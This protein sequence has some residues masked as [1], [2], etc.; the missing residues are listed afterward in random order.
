[1]ALAETLRRRWHWAGEG[2]RLWLGLSWAGLLLVLGLIAA[3]GRDAGMSYDEQLQ[4]QYGD[5]VV[6]WFAS[7]FKDDRATT[8]FDLYLYGGLFDAPA[9]W[10]ATHSPLG[11]LETR[12]LLTQLIA[13]LGI[14]ASWKMAAHVGGPR[15]GFFAGLTL[16]LTPCWIGHGMFNPKDI[17]FGSAAAFASLAAVRLAVGPAPLRWRDICL[18]GLAAGIALGVRPGGV[19]V[20]GYPCLAGGLRLLLELTRRRRE[21]E[22]LH[23]GALSLNLLACCVLVVLIAWPVMISAWP[24]AQLQPLTRPLEGIEAASHFNWQNKV[25]FEGRMIDSDKLPLRYLPV[26]FRLTLPETYLLAAM[27][28]VVMLVRLARHRSWRAEPALGLAIIAC[29]VV[30]P[31]AA[32]FI[33]RPVLYDAQRHVL[34]LLPPTAALAGCALSELLHAEWLPRAL[35]GAAAGVLV[36]SAIMVCVDMV[37][38][39]PYEYVYFNRLSG[40][41]RKRYRKFETDYWGLSYREGLEWVL[42]E[43]PPLHDGRRTRIAGCDDPTTDRL[44]YY[45][46]NMPGA[47]VQIR[48]VPGYD[49]ADLFLAVR[50]FNCHKVAGEILHVV[51]RQGAPLLYV[52]RTEH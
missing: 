31:L 30:L 3:F 24:W 21:G 49:E 39:H 12:H 38:L 42:R 1:M 34:F 8:F 2:S 32:V 44:V 28:A 4:M 7:G 37:Q 43:L 9:Q 25:L 19:F 22:S 35:R 15:A 6:A 46:D 14:V 29:S 47:R 18:G 13:L 5:M 36:G 40:G 27:A 52:R 10:L 23:L 48:V 26:W 51:R 41:L 16:A 33:K 11:L 50:R 20:L 17:P 45:R